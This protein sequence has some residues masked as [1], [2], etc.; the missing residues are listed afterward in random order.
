MNQTN[1]NNYVSKF[2]LAF[3]LGIVILTMFESLPNW[4]WTFALVPTVAFTMKYP[5]S[6]VIT[7]III[8]A[9]WALIHANI[10]LYPALDRDLEGIDL[11]IVG[12]VYSIPAKHGRSVRFDFIIFNATVA[13]DHSKVVLPK[14]V[15][16]NWYGKTPKL[17][18]GEQ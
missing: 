18:L 2:S 8:G 15:R 10:K 16:L 5:R 4:Q 1:I 17:Q 11:D 7:G 13:D 3:L 9:L 12:Q 14:K 6:I